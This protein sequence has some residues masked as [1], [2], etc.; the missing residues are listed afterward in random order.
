MR[1]VNWLDIDHS[2]GE[3]SGEYRRIVWGFAWIA[4]SQQR[5]RDQE[6]QGG[7]SAERANDGRMLRRSF[8]SLDDISS[9][10]ELVVMHH[11]V[12][13]CGDG[14]EQRVI[15]AWPGMTSPP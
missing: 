11:G 2:S 12:N 5:S 13:A 14:Q 10:S 3:R 6:H 15:L 9:G 8:A 1:S 7:S 4:I